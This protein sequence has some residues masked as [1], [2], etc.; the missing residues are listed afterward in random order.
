M[1]FRNTKLKYCCSLKGRIGWQNLRSDE[2]TDEGP[3]LITGMHFADG[4]VD[5]DKCFHISPERYAVDHNIHVREGDL[6]ITKDGSIGKLAHIGSLPGPACLNS[7]LLIIRPKN[8]FP[9][10]RFLLYLLKSEQF[11]RYILDEQSGTTFYGLSQESIANFDAAFPESLQDQ[12]QIAQFLDDATFQID[13]LIAKKQRLIALLDEERAAYI[14][15][16]V[17][18]GLDRAAP[19]SIRKIAWLGPVPIHWDF[20]SLRRLLTCIEQGSSPQV[21]DSS[22]ALDE[23]A[24]L[25]ISAVKKGRFDQTSTSACPTNQQEPKCS[26]C[27]PCP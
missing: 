10:T 2:F 27:V 18:Q 15:R 4:G 5:W 14:T 22:A 9:S 3:Y 11:Q 17:T 25:K 7:H 12:L 13:D 20:V 21:E 6:L 8:G 24:V 19:M 26:K 23:Y 1:K 16:A